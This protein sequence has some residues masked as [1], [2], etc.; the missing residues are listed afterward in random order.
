MEK[1][2]PTAWCFSQCNFLVKCATTKTTAAATEAEPATTT[3][4]TIS[5]DALEIDT[6]YLCITIDHKP[7]YTFFMKNV[8]TLIITKV[9]TPQCET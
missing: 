1:G 7:I 8:Y 2:F 4:T 9:V 6:W 5:N 3:T